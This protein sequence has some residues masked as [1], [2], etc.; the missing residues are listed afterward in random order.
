MPMRPLGRT[1]EQV[2][3]LGIGGFHLGIPSEAE[4]IRIVQT[5]LDHG[6]TFF[7]N[8]W[9]YHDGKS[10]ERLGRALSEGGQ[11]QKA[12][13]MTKLDGRTKQAASAQLEQSLQRLKT[14]M[15]DLVQMH[16]IIR[17]NDAERIFASGGAI[18]ALVEAKR[19]GKIR[20]TGFTGHKDPAIHLHMLEVAKHHGFDFDTVQMPINVMDAHYKS[21]EKQVLPLLRERNIGVLGMKPIGA[22][23]IL[24]SGAVRAEEC[25]RYSMSAPVSVVIT[26]CD[27]MGVL[28]QALAVALAFEPLSES[29]RKALLARTG[30]AAAEGRFEQFK[31]TDRFDG[32][33]AHPEWLGSA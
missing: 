8:C 1:G 12:F 25:L 11:R 9:D 18:E 2:S 20:F 10:E 27:S 15:I 26:G 21:F 5:A 28:K 7:D 13:V 33:A 17:M 32:T 14:D 24:E 4:A 30:K 22:N 31:T 23:I 6:V 19:A 3:L 29:E 16:E